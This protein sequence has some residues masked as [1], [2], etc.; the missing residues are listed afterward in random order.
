MPLDSVNLWKLFGKLGELNDACC[1]RGDVEIFLCASSIAFGLLALEVAA[2]FHFKVCGESFE[3]LKYFSFVL[4][5][6]SAL[7]RSLISRNFRKTAEI[8][9]EKG[10]KENICEIML[11]RNGIFK[12]LKY[13]CSVFYFHF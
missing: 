9:E 4:K 1:R 12:C 13:L 10:F 2:L 8:S 3:D 6:I 11:E 7:I 5:I